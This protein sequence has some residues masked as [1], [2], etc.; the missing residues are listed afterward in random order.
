MGAAGPYLGPAP[1]EPCPLPSLRLPGAESLLGE[2]PVR[3][4]ECA[5]VVMRRQRGGAT[6][7]DQP[8][9]VRVTE[10]GSDQTDSVRGRTTPTALC[11]C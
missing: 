3:G 11:L 7:T 6:G 2:S 10:I 1:P 9:S 5:D 4:S 8:D